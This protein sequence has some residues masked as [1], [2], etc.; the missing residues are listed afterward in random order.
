MVLL[1]MIELSVLILEFGSD[2]AFI[3]LDMPLLLG[4]RS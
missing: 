1:V 2:V 4:W 3:K